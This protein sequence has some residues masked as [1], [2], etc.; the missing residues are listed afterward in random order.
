MYKITEKVIHMSN[1]HEF[2]KSV[3]FCLFLGV[4]PVDVKIK[5]SQY[6]VKEKQF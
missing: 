6:T 5:N 1:S 2:T 4:F 3:L